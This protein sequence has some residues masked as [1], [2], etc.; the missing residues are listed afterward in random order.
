MPG[1][2]GGGSIAWK[3]R[4]A[5][6]TLLAG[7]ALIVVSLIWQSLPLGSSGWSDELGREYQ[8]ASA[9]LHELSHKYESRAKSN[10]V[11]A[12]WQRAKDSYDRLRQQLDSTRGQ[13]ARIATL[14]LRFG[15]VLSV[16]GAAVYFAARSK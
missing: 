1:T 11:P 13:S 5:L 4:A 10:E 7:V 15:I 6:L 12:E 8:S 3:E 2:E 16:V 14:L 9:D